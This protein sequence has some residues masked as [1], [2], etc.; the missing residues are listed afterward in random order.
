[1]DDDDGDGEPESASLCNPYGSNLGVLPPYWILR[2]MLTETW[3]DC[4]HRWHKKKLKELS[5]LYATEEFSAHNGYISIINSSHDG[6]SVAFIIGTVLTWRT[7]ALKGFKLDSGQKIKILKGA[8]AGFH[9]TNIYATLECIIL[10]GFQ[11]DAG[12][13]WIICR[14]IEVL[15]EDGYLLESANGNPTFDFRKS[16]LVPIN[17][18]DSG[19]A[20]IGRKKEFDVALRELRRKDVDISEEA[21]EIQVYGLEADIWSAGVILYNLLC[22]IP[23]FLGDSRPSISESAKDL[24]RKMLIKY[25]KR[26]ITAH[27]VLSWYMNAMLDQSNASMVYE[28]YVIGLNGGSSYCS[29]FIPNPTFFGWRKG[30]QELSEQGFIGSLKCW[31][32]GLCLSRSI[33]DRDVGEFIIPVPH[34]K[35][36]KLSSAGGRLVI[37]SDGVWDALSTES[38]LECSH[39]L[40]PESA[41]AQVE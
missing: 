2:I 27:G 24:V 40:A 16:E 21:D 30:S 11:G 38:A 31:R 28:C 20:K 37:S 18:I 3:Q 36:V 29:V 5:S 32:G 41:A 14:R 4:W 7:L 33:G 34:V 22:E 26:Q 19:K 1:M 39:G 8:C 10:E 13:A 15:E 35:Q 9:K 12:E 6:V 23:P 25:P 17:V